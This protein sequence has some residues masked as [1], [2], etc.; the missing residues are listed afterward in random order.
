M[1]FFSIIITTYNRP[2]KLKRAI[3]SV[4]NQ[5]FENYELII[6]NDGSTS[7]YNTIEEYIKPFPQIKYFFKK[8]EERSIA[9]NFGVENSSGTW[10]CFLDDDDYYEPNHLEIFHHKI[11]ELNHTP[12]LYYTISKTL[13][14]NGNLKNETFVERPVD[15]TP[16][17]YCL[18]VGHIPMNCTC[19]H[20]NSLIEFPFD[21][22]L[23]MTEDKHQQVRMMSKYKI[24]PILAH[25]AVVDR[26][27]DNTW[28]TGTFKSMHQEYLSYLKI[29]SLPE[30]KGKVR[31]SIINER[32]YSLLFFVLN[33]HFKQLSTSVFIRY[34]SRIFK[35]K[36]SFSVLKWIF[37]LYIKFTIHKCG[38]SKQ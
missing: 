37:K 36:S 10:I 19:Y 22:T 15:Y 29:F 18:T 13:D 16:Q 1:N 30:L 32:L 7:D 12:A 5:S 21:S 31:Q 9:R 35:Y 38:F 17:E 8:N 14:K 25:T 3:E 23:W 26:S 6:V 11:I 20:K 27:G 33:D 2:E 24:V 28:G 4:V 34:T